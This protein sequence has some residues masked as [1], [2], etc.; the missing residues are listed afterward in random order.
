M[1][2]GA[3]SFAWFMRS[4]DDAIDVYGAFG[5]GWRL[6]FRRCC[7][8]AYAKRIQGS[9]HQANFRARLSFFDLDQPKAADAN[10]P[11]QR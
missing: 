10:F 3:W 4:C 9:E 7:V 8:Q 1:Q 6:A 2:P 5:T 11:C